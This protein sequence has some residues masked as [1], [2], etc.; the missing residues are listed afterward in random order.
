MTLDYKM[1]DFTDVNQESNKK[2]MDDL[3]WDLGL[4]TPERVLMVMP[5]KLSNSLIAVADRLEFY[6]DWHEQQKKFGQLKPYKP[7]AYIHYF[8]GSIFP[9]DVHAEGHSYVEDIFGHLQDDIRDEKEFTK[10][11]NGTVIK[12][13][14]VEKVINHENGEEFIIDHEVNNPKVVFITNNDWSQSIIE[15]END[16]DSA[17]EVVEHVKKAIENGDLTL[18][19]VSYHGVKCTTDLS[20]AWKIET[21]DFKQEWIL[22]D[23]NQPPN[24][25]ALEELIP[26]RLRD[27]I[28]LF[29]ERVA[30][31]IDEDDMNEEVER[32]MSLLDEAIDELFERY[33][34]EKNKAWTTHNILFSF[35]N[36][37]NLFE[38]FVQHIDN[39]KLD[40]SADSEE[41]RGISDMLYGDLD[42]FMKKNP[43]FTTGGR[44]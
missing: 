5:E 43:M 11:Q 9:V 26:I 30:F 13:R 7:I 42:E 41:T 21:S 19:N 31:A 10:L 25:P 33:V 44:K 16:F 37:N 36:Q 18:E 38:S 23:G 29:S 40:M 8:D 27:Y 39:L 1:F 12:L 22:N 2:L 4:L 35:I 20:R 28:N 17:E 14:K 6:H 3:M 24:Q 34:N 15:Y 32:D